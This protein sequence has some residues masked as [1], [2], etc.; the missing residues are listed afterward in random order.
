MRQVSFASGSRTS[1]A[2][3]LAVTLRR[4]TSALSRSTHLSSKRRKDRDPDWL[5]L[6]PRA[7]AILAWIGVPISQ[8]LSHREVAERFN[9]YRPDIPN[10][11]LPAAVSEEWI[12]AQMR[13]LRRE[14]D[15]LEAAA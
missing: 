3:R 5:A 8:G 12:G 1:G 15:E 6:S 10:L 9:L 14:I 11:P 2:T 13:L 4:L 7:Q